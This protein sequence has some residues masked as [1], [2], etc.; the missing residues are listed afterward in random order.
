MSAPDAQNAGL[1]RAVAGTPVAFSALVAQFYLAPL[2]GTHEATLETVC[3]QLN[4]WLGSRLRWT[5]GSI[6][7][8][9]ERYNDEHLEYIST[10]PSNMDAEPTPGDF[11]ELAMELRAQSLAEFAVHCYGADE[12]GHASPFSV[13]FFADIPTVTPGQPLTCASVLRLSVAEDWPLDDFEKNVCEFA[14]ML[15]L[16]W[17]G[18][19]YSVIGNENTFHEEFAATAFAQARR[20]PGYDLSNESLFVEEFFDQVRSVNWLTMLG[21]E[22]ATR[23]GPLKSDPL[24]AISP[25]GNST[26]L[27]AGAHPE[28]GDHNWQQY[29]A[30]YRRA[31]QLIRSVR[32]CADLDFLEP[33]DEE[34]TEQWLRRYE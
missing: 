5:T 2:R 32:A 16:Q 25:L 18:A 7:S 1:L 9:T 4:R 29:P 11:E 3:A 33:W 20:F 10:Y 19:G 21:P 8:G 28:R 17:G 27:K 34:T 30:A 26:L 24:V 14:S 13:S 31:D 15:P 23:V 6:V 12:I 22:L